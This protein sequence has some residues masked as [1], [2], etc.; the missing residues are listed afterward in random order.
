MHPPLALLDRCA[1]ENPMV[2]QHQSG[3]MGVFNSMALQMLGVT[4]ETPAPEGGLIEKRDDRLT[5]YMEENAFVSYLQKTPM[6]DLPTLLDAYERAQNLYASHG[7]TTVQEGMMVDALIPLYRQLTEQNLLKVDVVGFPG[8]AAGEAFFN[9][10]PASVN[11]YERHFKI[12]GIKIFLD[13]SPQGKTAW[14]WV[15]VN[16]T[17]MARCVTK[18]FWSQSRMHICI[19]SRF[20]RIAM[21]TR[22]L[23]S[24]SAA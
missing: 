23:P 20:W 15:M 24:I 22:L 2:L 19:I 3:H 10:F 9:A 12:G 18:L 1:P 4:L 5:G 16:I 14:M 7:I 21:A 17:D 11:R 8:R 13:G 6:P